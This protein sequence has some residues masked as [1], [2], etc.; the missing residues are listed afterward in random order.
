MAT[1]GRPEE[2]P[3]VGSS[4]GAMQYRWNVGG[5][6]EGEGGRSY[7]TSEGPYATVLDHT[8]VA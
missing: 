2:A 3:G 8:F 4:S 6:R 5:G 1:L 7:I